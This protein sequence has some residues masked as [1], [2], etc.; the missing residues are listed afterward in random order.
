MESGQ[1]TL[2]LQ[3][4]GTLPLQNKEN[5]RETLQWQRHVRD[6]GES[7]K[8]KHALQLLQILTGS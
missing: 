3:N 4:Q 2:Y 1:F 5:N 7:C 8:H 6:T